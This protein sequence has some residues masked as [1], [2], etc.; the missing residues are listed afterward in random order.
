MKLGFKVITNQ[1]VLPY[2]ENNIL[3]FNCIKPIIIQPTEIKRIKT[4]LIV[5]IE[6]NYILQIGIHTV[7]QEKNISIVPGIL[8]INSSY[9]EELF[10]SIQN[11]GRG[12][13]NVFVGDA[14][15]T[16]TVIKIEEVEIIESE[17]EKIK[18][19]QEKN[20]PQ[21]KDIEFKIHGT[22]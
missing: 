22:H 4:G 21:K 9:N 15:A 2:I 13:V 16:G 5:E 11:K 7:L 6:K 17:I 12:Q 3:T 18:R 10:I 1:A 8:T 14:I 19:S 20:I